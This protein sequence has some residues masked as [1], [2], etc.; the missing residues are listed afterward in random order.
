[1]E[2]KKMGDDKKMAW[3]KL[4]S[5]FGVFFLIMAVWQI[6]VLELLKNGVI[7]TMVAM[8][9]ICAATVIIFGLVFALIR[10]LLDVFRQL[11]VVLQR[12]QINMRR[13]M[14]RSDSLCVHFRSRLLHFHRL[15]LALK[16]R[17]RSLVRF[18]RISNISL[19]V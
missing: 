8:I 3:K 2:D 1:M 10:T 12:R 14:V 19:R 6:V 18:R 9:L 16:R 7:G 15:Y 17:R 13:N 5:I 11:P 4:L